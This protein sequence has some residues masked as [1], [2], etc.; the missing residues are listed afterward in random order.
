[1]TTLD[2]VCADDLDEAAWM[3]SSVVE[4]DA[5][6]KY[7]TGISKKILSAIIKRS[8]TSP[9]HCRARVWAAPTKAQRRT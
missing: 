6:M 2:R 8:S 5:D 9:R 3:A 4:K 1:M 7:F